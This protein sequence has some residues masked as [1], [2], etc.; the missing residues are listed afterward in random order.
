MKQYALLFIMI[1]SCVPSVWSQKKWIDPA[2]TN[3]V[4]IGGKGWNKKECGL[5]NRLPKKAQKEVRKPLW[6][7]SCQTAGLYINFTTNSPAIIINYQVAGEFS[8]NHMPATG[9]SGV[10]LYVTTPKNQQVW[11]SPTHYSFGKTCT[12][13]YEKL[14]NEEDGRNFQLFLPLYNSV[15]NLQIGVDEQYNLEFSSLDD[16]NPIVTY[17]TSICQGACASRPGMAWTTILQRK[18]QYPIVN[19]GFSGNGRLEESLFDLMASVPA[20]LYIIDCMP[21]MW[22]EELLPLIYKRTIQGIKILHEHSDA[23]ILLVEHDGYMGDQASE[24]R[25]NCYTRSNLEL[26]RAYKQIQKENIQ[27]VYYLSKEEL[28]LTMDSQVDGTHASNLGMQQYADAYEKKILNILPLAELKSA[29]KSASKSTS[30]STSKSD[31]K[32]ALKSVPTLASTWE[33]NLAEKK[34]KY[35]KIKGIGYEK[36]CTRRDP[37]DIIKVGDT[38]YIYYTK[39]YGK[40][41]GYWGT[42]WCASSKDKGHTWTELGEVLS[43]GKKGTFDSFAVFTPNIIYTKGAYYMYYT[44]IRPTHGKETENL[45]ENNSLNDYTAIG[46]AKATIPEGGMSAQLCLINFYFLK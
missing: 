37:S 14:N 21:N 12:Y 41:A 7:L 39:I 34:F 3:Q 35:S 30:K 19:L 15:K 9:V 1:L 28:G 8:M 29:S 42:I 18:L 43:T 5:Y 32:P 17:G 20:K 10:D 44:G 24:D 11:C 4:V 16:I 13:T 27:K 40:A 23:P 22:S 46:V 38:Y 31:L 6:N 36:G 2:I 25:Y 26:K 45:F 33:Q